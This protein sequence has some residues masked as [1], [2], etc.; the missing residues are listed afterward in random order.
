MSVL[1]LGSHTLPCVCILDFVDN[2]RSR[3]GRCDMKGEKYD[4]VYV[5]R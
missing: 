4:Y 1:N 3:L 5:I 2:F